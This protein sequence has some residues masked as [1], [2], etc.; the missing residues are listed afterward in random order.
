[1]EKLFYLLIIFLLINGAGGIYFV[2]F[3]NELTFLLIGLLFIYLLFFIKKLK[4]SQFKYS[5]ITLMI[6]IFFLIINYLTAIPN[7][8]PK[9]YI[10]YLTIFI[11]AF[12][13]NLT[14][15]K[16]IVLYVYKV[17]IFYQYHALLTFILVIVMKN[18]FIPIEV[19]EERIYYS[20]YFIFFHLPEDLHK[21][22]VF[23]LDFIRNQG[24]FWEPG[25]LQLYM[26][27]LLYIQ[28]FYIGKF[29]FNVFLTIFIILTTFSTTGFIF[30]LLLI[31]YKF[32]EKINFKNFIYLI[33][34]G[35]IVILLFTPLIISNIKDKFF[36][37]HAMSSQV[38]LFD[39]MQSLFI[40]KE[41]PLT[42]IGLTQEV[43]SKLQKNFDHIL[44]MFSY[45][46]EGN[47]NSIMS[48]LIMWGIPIGFIWIFALYK[49]NIFSKEKKIFFFMLFIGLLAEPIFYRIFF[50]FLVFNGITN[51]LK[52][53]LKPKRKILNVT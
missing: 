14:I 11:L 37:D 12:L 48:V 25:I 53:L 17:L 26:N 10:Y 49:Q 30:M 9:T 33:P 27:I 19:S 5:F 21:I 15:K 43:Y 39:F 44:S 31:L 34:V 18:F 23:G 7:Q 32:K 3:R 45:N 6:L 38:R 46:P 35:I 42:G 4:Y 8:S 41:Y 22:T 2:F 40:I 52:K 29:T 13:M 1:M 16:N 50:V 28:L 47:T 20:L 36:G 24:L 51:I